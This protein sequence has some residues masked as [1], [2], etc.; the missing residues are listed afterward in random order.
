L[1]DQNKNNSQLPLNELDWKLIL[2]KFDAKLSKNKKNQS[3]DIEQEEKCKHLSV[4]FT[5]AINGQSNM[6]LETDLMFNILNLKSNYGFI[7]SKLKTCPFFWNQHAFVIR[8]IIWRQP[9]Q[10]DGVFNL[11]YFL[12]SSWL[13]TLLNLFTKLF[14]LVCST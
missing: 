7:K 14:F 13:W 8:S 1:I 11:A 12:N 10:S 4:M 5:D 2:I 9:A 6:I 3:L